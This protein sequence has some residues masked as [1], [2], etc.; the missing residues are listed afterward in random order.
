MTYEEFEHTVAAR[1]FNSD[2]CKDISVRGLTSLDQ[3]VRTIWPDLSEEDISILGDCVS[4]QLTNGSFNFFVL[5]VL[6]ASAFTGS[7]SKSVEYLNSIG[8]VA[9]YFAVELVPFAGSG[10][11]AF[12]SRTRVRPADRT[13]SQRAGNTNE[14]QCLNQNSESN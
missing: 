4:Q 8:S 1:Y 9:K 2:A 13:H 3:A 5:F 11:T 10:L 12:A 7:V 14:A 6:A